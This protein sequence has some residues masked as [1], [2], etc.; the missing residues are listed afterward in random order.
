MGRTGDFFS[1][2]GFLLRRRILLLEALDLLARDAPEIRK[3]RNQLGQGASFSAA[4]AP[5]IPRELLPMI[6]AIESQG[7]PPEQLEALGAWPDATDLDDLPVA[8]ILAHAS[9]L[10]QQ[11]KTVAEALSSAVR[12]DDPEPL[13][14]A[15][16]ALVQAAESTQSLAD[17]MARFPLVFS[18]AVQHSVRQ[19]ERNGDAATTFRDLALALSRGWFLPGSGDRDI[20]AVLEDDIDG[21]QPR[22]RAAISNLPSSSRIVIHDNAP[23]FVAWLEKSFASIRLMTLDHDLG[24]SRDRGGERFDPESGMQV[25][26]AL[27]KRKPAFP[28]LVHSSNPYDAPTMVRRLEEAGWTVRRIVPWGDEWIPTVWLDAARKLLEG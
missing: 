1:Q 10:L 15:I 26:E 11:G 14:T 9:I 20:V 7:L 28:I 19:M 4:L 5:Y 3:V 18:P 16:A 2:L 24:P 17:A 8:R 12:T 21:R 13:R 27:L 22:F 25:V 6:D 23:D